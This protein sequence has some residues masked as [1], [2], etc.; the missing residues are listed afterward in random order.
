VL[1]LF[2]RPAGV[3]WLVLRSGR[4]GHRLEQ[5]AE[6]A[7]GLRVAGDVM[8]G[9]CHARGVDPVVIRPARLE[10][11]VFLDEVVRAG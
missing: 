9:G 7:D 3:F 5:A 8:A 6:A 11:L 1:P 4:A 10:E 2:Q